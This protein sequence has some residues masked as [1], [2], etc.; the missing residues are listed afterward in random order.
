MHGALSESLLAVHLKRKYN[1]PL[2]VTLYG[3]DVNRFAKQFPSKYLTKFALI[4]S[5]AIICQSSFLKNGVYNVGIKDN[6]FFII[7]MGA[8]LSKFKPRDKYNARKMLGLPSNKKMILFVGHLFTRKGVEYLIRAVNIIKEKDK[9]VLCC[10][11]GSGHLENDLKRLSQDLGLSNYIRFLGEKKRDDIPF[12]MNACDVFVLPS[13]SEGLPVVLC[14]ALAC[15]KPVVATRVAG[16]PELINKDVGFLVEPKD[17]DALAEKI[18]SSLNKRWDKN[19]LIKRAKEFSVT[20]SA[21][22]VLNVYKSFLK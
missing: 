10:V 17:V 5:D 20:N 22:K 19:K 6:E 11:I 14:E 1:K 16:T 15:G 8:L 3:E 4:N 12:Y 18:T 9:K 2:I 7:P 13:L 21:K